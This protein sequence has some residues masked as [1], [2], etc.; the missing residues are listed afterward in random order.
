[1]KRTITIG[2]KYK[3]MIDEYEDLYD[4]E[5]FSMLIT[6]LLV[7]NKKLKDQNIDILMVADLIDNYNIDFFSLMNCLSMC[8]NTSKV[9]YIEDV[10]KIED[11]PIISM[12]KKNDNI[13]KKN[14]KVKKVVEEVDENKEEVES[15]FENKKEID[16][17]E[18]ELNI[19]QKNNIT[20]II[21]DLAN[22]NVESE[23]EEV[24]KVEKEDEEDNFNPILSLGLDLR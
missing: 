3:E 21:S 1:M 22:D 14:K 2:N 24:V 23:R 16:N 7:S 9:E 6:K 11:S 18:P 20:P 13:I 15:I 4:K 17:E 10:S 12:K 5:E 19:I 8:R